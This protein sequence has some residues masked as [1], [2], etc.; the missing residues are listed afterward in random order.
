MILEVQKGFGDDVYRDI[1]RVSELFRK[2]KCG[3]LIPEGKICKVTVKNSC[4]YLILR[5]FSGSLDEKKDFILLDERTRRQLNLNVNDKEEFDF[6]P[7]G[8]FDQFR[9]AWNASDPAYRI[10]ARMGLLSVILGFVGI[11]LG[12]ISFF[13]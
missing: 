5:G 10:S 8:W 13:R 6:L 7:L 3:K 4:I 11:L 9:W 12:T 1:G 2:T